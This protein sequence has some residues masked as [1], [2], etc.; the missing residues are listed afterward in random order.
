[1][2]FAAAAFIFAFM[3]SCD[4]SNDNDDVPKSMN[5]T[6]V[7]TL[8]GVQETPANASTAVGASTLLYNIITRAFTSTTTYSGLSSAVT[9]GHIHVG[10][11]V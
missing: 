10:A 6:F 4:S 2:R 5:K 1:M 9:A 3:S 7:A 8:T 11:L